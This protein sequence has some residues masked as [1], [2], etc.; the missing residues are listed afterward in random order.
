MIRNEQGEWLNTDVF[1]QEAIQFLKH[2]YYTDAPEGSHEFKEYWQTQLERCRN[3]YEIDGVRITGHHYHYLNFCQIKLTDEGD[4]KNVRTSKK[5]KTFPNFYDGDYDFFWS[6]EIAEK[7]IDKDEYHRLQLKVSVKEDNLDGGRYLICVKARRKGYSYKSASIC[8][9]IY[10][11][12]RNSLVLIGAGIEMYAMGNFKMVKDYLNFH[13]KHCPGFR[14][15]RLIDTKDHIKSGFYEE[16]NGV[17][18]EG[19]Y[20]SEI[21]IISFKDNAD[22]ARGKD[23]NLVIFEEGGKFN[24]LKDSFYATDDT[25]RDGKYISG[26]ALIFGTSG[27]MEK[28]GTLDLS[29][30]FYDPEQFNCLAFDNIWDTNA[31]GSYAGLFHPA[32]LNMVGFM[33]KQGNSKYKEAL[34]HINDEIEKRRKSGKGSITVKKYLTENPRT[35]AEAFSIS[36]NN[37]FPTVEL[38]AQLNYIMANNLH[39]KLSTPV[40]LSRGLD[41]KVKAEPDYN[42][43]LI[44]IWTDRPD[45][46]A[47]EGSV[48]IYEF[49][50]ANAP[51]GLYKIGY[52][53]YRQDQGTSLAC[54]I[55]YKSNNR[56]EGCRD[57]IVAKYLG[58]PKTADEC[59]RI[60]EML[61]EFY[62]TELMYENEVVEVKNYFERR[63]KLHLL[64]LQPD[65][66]IST[67]I[68]NS[69]V[70]RVYGCHMN[71]K[72]KDAG[73]KYIKKW[74][75]EERDVDEDGNVILNLHK[76]YDP[77]LIK[78]LINYNRK[79]NFDNCMAFMQVMFQLEEEVLDKVYEKKEVNNVANEISNFFNIYRK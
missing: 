24:N 32:H 57:E 73:E 4:S 67:N 53:P 49:P 6:Y 36:S 35:P 51:K 10:N 55:V 58:R 77:V 3:G 59:N 33:S 12:V 39:V 52:D 69:K 22:A 48:V 61:T 13:N 66:V 2:G 78:E 29:T 28:G 70:R 15:N 63:K 42:S 27:D 76:M 17:K 62:N 25:L 31:K 11:T 26:M 9:N 16:I 19:G 44:P 20:G 46:S 45:P 30:M 38:D 47:L 54:I 72:M 1:R 8:A 37:D 79:G 5:I 68:K 43:K 7:G 14:K 50:V 60:A 34:N 75:L 71:E 41:G 64:A 18:T 40:T 21:M 23:A 56:F 65:S 74:L